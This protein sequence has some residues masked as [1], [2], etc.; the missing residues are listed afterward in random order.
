VGLIIT[1]IVERGFD[2]ELGGKAATEGDHSDE[3]AEA[4]PDEVNHVRHLRE[5]VGRLTA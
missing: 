1:V 2:E 5:V 3:E 4:T